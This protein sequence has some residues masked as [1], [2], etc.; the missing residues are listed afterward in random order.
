MEK[1]LHSVNKDILEDLCKQSMVILKD[2]LARK[3]E[4]KSSR[5]IFSEDDLRK[6]AE[7]VLAEYPVIFKY[8]ILIKE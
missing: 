8:N 4:G 7:D 3:Y 2:K 1:Y 5:T 6:R